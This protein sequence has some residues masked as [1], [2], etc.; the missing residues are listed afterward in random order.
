MRLVWLFYRCINNV[1]L[2]HLGQRDSSARLVR[3]DDALL[4]ERDYDACSDLRKFVHE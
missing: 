1:A 4:A 3:I 2:G